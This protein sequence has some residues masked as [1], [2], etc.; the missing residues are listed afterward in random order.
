MKTRKMKK[1]M[2]GIMV[3]FASLNAMAFEDSVKVNKDASFNLVLSDVSKTTHITITDKRNNILFE[4]TVE[5]GDSYS[6]TFN[7]ELL[8]EGEYVVEI[9]NDLKIKKVTIEVTGQ[10]LIADESGSE[11]FYKPVLTK[12]G[13]LVYLMQYSP[14]GAPLYVSLYNSKNELLYEGTLTG[15]TNLGKIFDFSRTMKGKYSFYLESRDK[16]FDYLV[17]LEK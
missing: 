14:D 16:G 3:L 17:S 9:E 13:D 8:P 4:Q 7:L 10:G 1:V 5:K 2:M 15:K 11:E 12:K 6:K